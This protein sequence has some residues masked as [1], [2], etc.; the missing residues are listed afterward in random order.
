MEIITCDE[1]KN[2]DG[3]TADEKYCI[4]VLTAA[5]NDAG[6]EGEYSFNKDDVYVPYLIYKENDIWTLDYRPSSKENRDCLPE[7]E[8]SVSY[9]TVECFTN[10]YN[11]CKHL[12]Q[13]LRIK[14][15]GEFE[16]SNTYFRIPVGTVVLVGNYK[17]EAPFGLPMNTA[18]P[19]L[20]RIIDSRHSTYTGLIE[21]TILTD[22]GERRLALHRQ[23]STDSTEKA[24]YAYIMTLEDFMEKTNMSLK[25]VEQYQQ[26]NAL[27][28]LVLSCKSSILYSGTKKPCCQKQ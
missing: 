26:L 2:I 25:N 24:K 6:Y 11:L 14:K 8:M 4:E 10:I 12:L 21:Y 17:V 28:H 7:I 22:S 16:V 3:L 1:P 9:S 19:K 18:M 23:V 15:P 20:G 13:I 27:I 5:L